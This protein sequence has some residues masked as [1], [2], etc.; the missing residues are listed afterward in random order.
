VPVH[1]N[2]SIASSVDTSDDDEDEANCDDESIDC[3][4]EVVVDGGCLLPPSIIKTATQHSAAAVHP[5]LL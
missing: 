5:S 3:G 2:D 4:I 1:D